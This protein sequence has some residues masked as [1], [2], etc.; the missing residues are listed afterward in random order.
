MRDL[1]LLGAGGH[2]RVLLALMRAAGYSVLGVCDPHLASSGASRWEGLDVLGDD[3]ALLDRLGPERVALVLGIGQLSTGSLRERLYDLWRGRGYAFPAL[4]HPAAWIAG[5]A[6]LSDGVQVMA[7]AII[8]PGCA[9]GENST[10]NTRASID[11][12]CHIAAH[13]H[14]APGATLCGSIH[15]DEGAFIGAGSVL[16]QGVR[17]G[18]RAVVGAGTTLVRDLGPRQII[19]GGAPRIRAKPAAES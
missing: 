7:G 17:V 9:I 16:V 15:V 10:I 18:E 1:V 19:I 13:V 2:A 5:D 12:D 8:Q 3:A 4:V 6:L 14:V 11:H